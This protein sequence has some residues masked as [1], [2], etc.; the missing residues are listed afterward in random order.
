MAAA[1]RASPKEIYLLFLLF[2]ILPSNISADS[3]D[4]HFSVNQILLEDSLK[5]SLPANAEWSFSALDLERGERLIDTGNAR[6]IPLIPGSIVKLF[7]TAAILDL[8]TKEKIGLDTTVAFDGR[9]SKGVLQSNLYLKGSGN[10]FLSARDMR[11]AVEE[12]FSKGIREIT[13]DIIADDSFF[14]INGR[15]SRYYGPAYSTPS[16][17]GLD[18]HTVSIMVSGKDIKIQPPNEAVRVGFNPD[19]RP[20]IRQIDDLTY[21]VSG[22]LADSMSI[23]KRFPLKDPGLYAGGTLKTLLKESGVDVKGIIR[24]GKMPPGVTEISSIKPKDLSEIIKDTNINSLNVFADNLLLLL[25]AKRFGEPGTVENGI[26]AVETL[27]KDLDIGTDGIKIADGSGLSLENRVTS[28][29]MTI[30]LKRACE[31]PWFSSF[32][33][34][35]PRAGIDGTLKGINYKNERVRAKT[36]Q[37]NNAYLIASSQQTAAMIQDTGY[38]PLNPPLVRGELKN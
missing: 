6:D 15:G 37:M 31:K 18:M 28:E 12:I 24:K 14:D 27:L 25:G 16:A 3:V 7:I 2:L 35:F 13:G 36:G 33:E 32:Y 4:V 1:A 17:L 10:A 29:K 26:K 19:G 20:N 11:K 38:T 21:E 22:I 34:S 30:F 23:R 5:S 9:I 8:D